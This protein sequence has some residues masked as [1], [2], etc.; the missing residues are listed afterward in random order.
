MEVKDLRELSW[1]VPKVDAPMHEAER[2]LQYTKVIRDDLA[3]A[4]SPCH[5]AARMLHYAGTTA[6]WVRQPTSGYRLE[7]F[8]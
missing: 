7:S 1:R 5:R 4:A 3:L 6:L 8:I 2:A